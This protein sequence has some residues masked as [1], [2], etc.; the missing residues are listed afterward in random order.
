VNNAGE[1]PCETETADSNRIHT[2]DIHN[3]F[4]SIRITRI[5]HFTRI[6]CITHIDKILCLLSNLKNRLQWLHCFPKWIYYTDSM[7]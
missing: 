1:N 6:I 3:F 4:C 7:F 5:I 2:S